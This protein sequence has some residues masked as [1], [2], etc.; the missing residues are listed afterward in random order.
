MRIAIAFSG[1]DAVQKLRV[2]PLARHLDCPVIDLA[3]GFK[4]RFDTLILVKKPHGNFEAIRKACDRLIWDPLDCWAHGEGR[5]SQDV[6]A[7]WKK[8]VAESGCDELIATSPACRLTMLPTGLPVHLVP[9]ACDERIDPS[10]GNPD[11]PVV[12]YGYP[13]FI[14][15]VAMDIYNACA[16]LGREFVMYDF[17]TSPLELI[18]GA[19]AH[20]CLRWEPHDY[21]L[22][23]FCK[24]VVK[25]ENAAAAGVPVMASK[26]SSVT[27][28]WPDAYAMGHFR[29][30]WPRRINKLLTRIPPLSGP[31]TTDRY[32]NEMQRVVTGK[33][34]PEEGG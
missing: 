33:G 31:Y 1:S 13:D 9:H 11:G 27:S 14:G 32:V 16:S 2:E 30:D 12:Y 17:R 7:F 15:P 21:P 18:K 5:K 19:S 20:I 29:V 34:D 28:L 22:N 23:Q 10:W 25:L 24:P 6:P 4:D 3:D 26:H 8:K